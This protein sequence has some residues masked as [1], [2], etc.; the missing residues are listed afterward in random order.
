MVVAVGG[1]AHGAT[2]MMGGLVW[3][4]QVARLAGPRGVAGGLARQQRQ[5]V[6]LVGQWGW[7]EG[8]RGGRR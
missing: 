2:G 1:E 4:R 6:R 8:L 7:W 3:W 5:V